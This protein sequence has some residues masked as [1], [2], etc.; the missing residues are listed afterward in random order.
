ME[1]NKVYPNSKFILTIRDLKSWL[2]SREKH[3]LHNQKNSGGDYGG[4]WLKIDKDGWIGEWE[5]HTK[6]VIEY[7]KNRPK[8]LLIMNICNGDGWEK[9]C[10]FLE[11]PIPNISFTH[12]NKSSEDIFKK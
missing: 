10:P 9:S 3:V 5:G 1:Y 7:F 6:E 11:L 2:N 12:E 4:N 8:D